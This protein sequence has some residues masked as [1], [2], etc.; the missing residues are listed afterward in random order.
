MN[1][2]ISSE[3]FMKKLKIF[4]KTEPFHRTTEEFMKNLNSLQ[5][6]TI[7][8]EIKREMNWKD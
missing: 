2:G 8:E 3:E 7:A 1:F 5:K 6:N 4:R